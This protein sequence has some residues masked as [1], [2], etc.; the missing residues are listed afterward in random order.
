MYTVSRDS[1]QDLLFAPGSGL[2]LSPYKGLSLHSSSG[3][4]ILSGPFFHSSFYLSLAENT[5]LEQNCWIVGSICFT[6]REPEKANQTPMTRPVVAMSPS[7]T[8]LFNFVLWL[9]F[10]SSFKSCSHSSCA[11]IVAW[12]ELVDIYDTA[13]SFFWRRHVV[14]EA[15]GRHDGVGR[16][17]GL[18][19]ACSPP[20]GSL[21]VSHIVY[22]CVWGKQCK[23]SFG[24]CSDFVG[25]LGVST[26]V[27]SIW[28]QKKR[29]RPCS[30]LLMV[31][32]WIM[33]VYFL[34]TF[35][36][37][38]GR[39]RVRHYIFKKIQFTSFLGLLF[40]TWKQISTQSGKT[41]H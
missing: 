15:S 39:R 19:F 32:I 41:H 37:H 13:L 18:V 7:K 14:F 16:S 20:Q 36:Q 10:P 2:P 33:Y 25:M 31:D 17:C 3:Q 23:Y 4:K 12:F 30:L 27:K 24:N 9:S 11:L 22:L 28:E 6:S 40:E 1:K 26:L 38:L 21:V 5:F 35:I 34:Y 29:C 8:P